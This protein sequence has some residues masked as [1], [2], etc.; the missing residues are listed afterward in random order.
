MIFSILLSKN[1]ITNVI[2]GGYHIFQIV[3]ESQFFFSQTGIATLVFSYLNEGVRIG[4]AWDVNRLGLFEKALEIPLFRESQIDLN[5]LKLLLLSKN[6]SAPIVRLE[7]N[8]GFFG[9][10][11]LFA[12]FLQ[13]YFFD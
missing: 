12:Y 6:K 11:Q 7:N 3:S 10:K 1:L 13:S 9:F 8:L 2:L 5:R 4:E